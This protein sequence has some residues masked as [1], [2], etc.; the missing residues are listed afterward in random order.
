MSKDVLFGAVVGLLL[1]LAYCYWKQVQTAYAH[2]DLISATGDL[3][4]SG[5][6]FWDQV[7]KL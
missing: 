2:R 6:N 3:V 5:S 7:K 4:T 1:G